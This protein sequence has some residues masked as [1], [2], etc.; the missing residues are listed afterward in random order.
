M[1]TNQKDLIDFNNLFNDY[2]QRFVHFAF[3]FV[4]EI[5]LAEDFAIEA[6]MSYWENRDKL[7]SD[8][9]PP[10]YILTIIKNKCISH[11]RHLQ[12][13]NNVEEK[14]ADHYYWKLRTQL[15][16][17]EV[18][19]PEEIF[20]K[21]IMDIVDKALHKLPENTRN[22]FILSR[23]ENLSHK[24]IAEKMNMTP[25]GVEFHICKSLKILRVA[26]KDYMPS[27]LYFLNL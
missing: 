25:K 7:T 4:K 24:E 22:I 18:C 8:T 21:E 20:S 13:R 10:A 6:F 23:F 19:D 14:L 5:K 9:N 15:V 3:S 2:Y 11:L 27:V 17:L 16:T 1:M 12:I 26:L